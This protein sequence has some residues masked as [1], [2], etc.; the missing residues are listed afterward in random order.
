M[1]IVTEHVHLKHEYQLLLTERANLKSVNDSIRSMNTEIDSENKKLHSEIIKLQS[2]IPPPII[3]VTDLVMISR[4]DYLGTMLEAGITCMNEDS[5]S[6]ME[7]SLTSKIELVRIAPELVFPIDLCLKNI[8]DCEDSGLKAQ[9]KAADYHVSGI[10]LVFGDMPWGYHGWVI[11]MD[12]EFNIW[13][14]ETMACYEYAGVWYKIGDEGYL[15]KKV[16]A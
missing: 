11:T 14:L 3:P 1:C 8:N 4:E 10:R 7:F 15:P 2:L 5:P 16:F 13:W 12:K 9:C 6:D